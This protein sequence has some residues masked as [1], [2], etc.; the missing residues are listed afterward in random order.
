MRKHNITARYHAP[1]YHSYHHSVL[2]QVHLSR[3]CRFPQQ[4]KMLRALLLACKE[5][6]SIKSFVFIL[7]R[8]LG[9]GRPLRQNLVQNCWYRRCPPVPSLLPP[10][11][12]S[13]SASTQPAPARESESLQLNL[14]ILGIF[15]SPNP[16]HRA[17]QPRPS[18]PHL[19]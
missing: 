7:P 19:L 6:V 5:G 16:H 10:S 4:V 9:T 8:F 11:Q 18:V 3:E 15:S 17:Q 2:Q 12:T 14:S 13:C 1:K